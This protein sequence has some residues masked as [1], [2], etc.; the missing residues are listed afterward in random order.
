V[1]VWIAFADLRDSSS[2]RGV[3]NTPIA[4]NSVDA[5][6]SLGPSNNL[7][8]DFPADLDNAVPKALPLSCRVGSVIQF[9]HT[10]VK[11]LNALDSST[12]PTLL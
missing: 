9:G 6:T 3:R 7:L 12:I 5:V 2:K 1:P 11:N 10:L 8:K 4:G